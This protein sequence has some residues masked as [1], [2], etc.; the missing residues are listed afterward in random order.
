LVALWLTKQPMQRRTE[1]QNCVDAII[2]AHPHI[3][4]TRPGN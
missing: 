2:P 1:E 4:V 3:A